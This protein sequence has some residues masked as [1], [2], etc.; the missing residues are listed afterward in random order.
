MPTNSNT[1]A[2]SSHSGKSFFRRFL[3][4]LLLAAV[5]WFIFVLAGSVLRKIA[6]AQLAELTN[7]KVVAGTV[8]FRLNGS[9]L[10]EKLVITPLRQAEYDNTILRADSVYARFG[11][12]SLLS[13]HPRLEK[14]SIKDF[15]FTA[16]EDL[17]S[18]RWNVEGLKIPAYGDG[19]GKIPFI[20]L[21]RGKLQY[22][23]VSNGW[24]EI[25][26]AAPVDMR[27]EPAENP[28][29]GCRFN[30]TAQKDVSGRS[31]LEGYYKPG[32]V[33]IVGG[34]S[35]ADI[36]AFG[37]NW[38]IDALTADLD[39]SSDNNY[40]LKIRIKDFSRQQM[41]STGSTLSTTLK[42][43]TLTTGDSTALT[44]SVAH[45]LPRFLEKF[46]LFSVLQDF[47]N[48][49]RPGG[50]IAFELE[51]SG[52]LERISESKLTGRVYCKDVSICYEDF[53]YAVTNMTGQ[54]GFTENSVF[55]NNLVGRHGSVDM[56]FN[57]WVKDFGPNWRYQVDITSD[58]MAL[59]NDLYEAL[60]PQEKLFW[61]DF[62]PKGLSAI[63]YRLIR[64]SP[65]DKQYFLSV[66]LHGVDC[67][68]K[69][70]PY[71]LKN[72]NGTLFFDRQGVTFSDLVSQADGKKIT[73]NGKTSSLDVNQPVYD[74]S[75][76]AQ[77][78]PLDSTLVAAMPAGP[79]PHIYDQ[80]DT[81]GLIRIEN[82]T[83]QVWSEGK[84]KQTCY[85][86]SM[87]TG[88]VELD[89]VLF[90][91]LPEPLQKF[92]SDL[93]PEGKINCCVD[94]DGTVGNLY[95]DYRITVDCL[96]NS[97]DLAIFPYPL[98]NMTGTLTV[99]K[100][101]IRIDD[102][103]ANAAHNIQITSDLPTL[104]INGSVTLSGDAFSRVR[105]VIFADNI[106]FDEQLGTALPESI[107]PFY[108]GLSPTGRFD[109]DL[110]D[111]K[112]FID[113]DGG[114]YID[115]D[116]V[117][118]FK[119]CDFKTSALITGL[120]AALK[121]KC[122][123]KI[124]DWFRSGR[125][126]LVAENIEVKGKSLKNLTADFHYDPSLRSWLTSN[127]VADCYGGRLEGG[128]E[129]KKQAGKTPEYLLYAGFDNID[130]KRFLSDVEHK[131]S[132]QSDHTSGKM[133]GSL[134]LG[135]RIDDDSSRI[136]RCRLKITDMQVGKPS[137]MAKLL[138]VLNLT[139]PKDFVFEQ[140]LVDSYIKRNKLSFRQFDLS[141]EAV[142]FSGT[143]WMDLQTS[144]VNL[145]LAARGRRLAAV[146][147]SVLQSLTDDISNAV[148]QMDVAGDLYD[149]QITT[150]TLPVIRK[151]MEILGTKPSSRR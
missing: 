97:A 110:E 145:V 120:D 66:G 22:V 80:F 7:T 44:T 48:W 30:I 3:D 141:G 76:C 34:L 146:P 124:G 81:A 70:F 57:G 139:E 121:A 93:Q 63:D 67:I 142:S 99:T 38:K 117:V 60:S 119:A 102:I 78:I 26:A 8:R 51:V 128:G 88:Q 55:L 23:K 101:N 75:I 103:T 50:Q 136:G 43:G 133:A 114:K 62:S 107:R 56:T 150:R 33:T 45:Y 135:G 138:Y 71:P 86:L 17:D 11:A 134:S 106:F 116:C 77:N 58:N 61:S 39:Y 31:S 18:G 6:I 69:D 5:L 130:L 74:I 118:N 126:E 20:R 84:N 147:P 90:G 83:G 151:T 127:I 85:R 32:K 64:N 65:T 47:F 2:E 25:V 140:M 98:K 109:L 79:E 105:F 16:R 92:V 54:V 49:Y 87:Q 94:L 9:V 91:L 68:Y 96:G 95:P 73:L 115:F 35:S 53:P 42:T 14:I 100:D 10:I 41:D 13:L 1:S 12:I 89:G 112:F 113:A 29:D 104:K 148:V 24:S 144:N 132:S 149:P 59:D 36:T 15:V 108:F 46:A 82:L 111:I 125:A 52:N 40:L 143:G 27:L 21:K 122:S 28:Q 37:Q 4:V 129:L 19:S 131:E 137:P 123:Y 72:L